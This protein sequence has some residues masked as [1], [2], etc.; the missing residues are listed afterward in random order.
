MTS[1]PVTRTAAGNFVVPPLASIL[2]DYEEAKAY[3]AGLTQSPSTAEPE[4]AEWN[5]E[6]DGDEDA[7]HPETEAID[8]RTD[9]PP[10]PFP[11]WSREL[12]TES[13]PHEGDV[14]AEHG[15]AEVCDA[16]QGDAELEV[17]SHRRRRWLPRLRRPRSAESS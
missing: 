9:I 1:T 17:V 13:I 2:N 4:F 14:L 7:P 10:V 5:G 12:A 16:E 15:D 3:I 8:L 11:G 6:W